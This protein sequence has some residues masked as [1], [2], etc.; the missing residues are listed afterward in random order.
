MDQS[1]PARAALTNAVN[2]AITNGAP[3]YVN[4]EPP[5]RTPAM[6]V[7][8][9]E[10]LRLMDQVEKESHDV[11]YHGENARAEWK[12]QQLRERLAALAPAPA[13]V[14]AANPAKSSIVLSVRLTSMCPHGKRSNTCCGNA[15]WMRV[16]HAINRER[17]DYI[18]TPTETYEQSGGRWFEE[19]PEF[20]VILKAPD[21]NYVQA[22]TPEAAEY[23][24]RAVK[25]VVGIDVDDNGWAA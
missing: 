23:L 7:E 6:S 21:T 16:I 15:E 1:N 13:P 5:E 19:Y 4:Q 9:S 12:E 10:V 17:K 18:A 3:V 24:R 22:K 20:R 14:P 2:R 8:I 11:E 25:S